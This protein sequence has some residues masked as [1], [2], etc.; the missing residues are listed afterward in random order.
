MFKIKKL[1]DF[2]FGHRLSKH[3][4]LCKNVHGHNAKVEIIL[5]AKYLND[6]DMIIDFSDLKKIVNH[7]FMDK[8]DHCSILNEEDTETIKSISKIQEEGKIICVPSDP[9][10]EYL[11]KYFFDLL[12]EHFT[13]N[14]GHILVD[15][16]RIWENDRS[17]AEY[18]LD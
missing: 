8:V 16:V 11:C 13:I 10:A 6:N 18:S 2:P 1:F 12:N 9:T 4:G 17:M 3:Y 5:E 7:L 14:Y 15:R